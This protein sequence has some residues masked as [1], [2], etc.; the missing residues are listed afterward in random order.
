MCLY[1]TER[2]KEVTSSGMMMMTHYLHN[3]NIGVNMQ[4]EG[5]EADAK[6]TL[7]FDAYLF[8]KKENCR[9]SLTA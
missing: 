5:V 9:T 1:V 8:V 2:A 7:S 6:S 3:S 4:Q